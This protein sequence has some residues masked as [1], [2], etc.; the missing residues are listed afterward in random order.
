[1]TTIAEHIAFA[2]GVRL[3]DGVCLCIAEYRRAVVNVENASG[4]PVNMK[5]LDAA[6]Q[7]ESDALRALCRGIGALKSEKA[8]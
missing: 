4:H 2:F 5:R 7:H 8:Q 1:V 3:P 6:R